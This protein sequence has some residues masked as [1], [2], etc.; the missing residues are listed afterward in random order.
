MPHRS[1]DNGDGK[2]A[3]RAGDVDSPP[4]EFIDMAGREWRATERR[5]PRAEW[6]GADEQSDYAGYGVGWLIFESGPETRRLRLYSK[7]W[8]RLDD[9]GLSRLCGRALRIRK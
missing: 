5:I 4:R 3:G 6:T 9:S 8:W 7:S 2:I 1:A